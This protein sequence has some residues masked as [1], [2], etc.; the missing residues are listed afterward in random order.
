ML[1][2]TACR[3]TYGVIWD[4]GG[5]SGGSREQGRG[6]RKKYALAAQKGACETS[7]A[8]NMLYLVAVGRLRAWQVGGHD[9]RL[10]V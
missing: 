8:R 9:A 3:G 6:N 7:L 4:I 5:A 1:G 10:G 2:H